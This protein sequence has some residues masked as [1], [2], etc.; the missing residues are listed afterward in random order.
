[1]N[2]LECKDDVKHIHELSARN[3]KKTPNIGS[4]FVVCRRHNYVI[5]EWD[6]EIEMC[7]KCKS[8]RSLIDNEI[9][10]KRIEKQQRF[11][12]DNNLPRFAPGDGLCS[13]CG[14]QIYSELDGTTHIT[15]C[16]VCGWSYCE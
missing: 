9:I 4:D 2:C 5:C 13:V 16:P 11:C 10:L 1:M 8:T 14:E 7:T 3:I 15:G 12:D 6:K